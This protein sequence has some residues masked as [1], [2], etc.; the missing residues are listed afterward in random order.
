MVRMGIHRHPPKGTSSPGHE[1]P[2][3]RVRNDQRR[4]WPMRF[5]ALRGARVYFAV[6]GRSRP[7]TGAA[8]EAPRG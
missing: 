8:P 1:R 5:K 2:N 7:V 4:R 6:S 3:N